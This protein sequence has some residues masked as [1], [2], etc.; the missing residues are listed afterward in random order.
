MST[1]NSTWSLH[2]KGQN[3]ELKERDRKTGSNFSKKE[4]EKKGSKPNQTTM[5]GQIIF[6]VPSVANLAT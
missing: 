2:Q 4:K 3:W 1:Y 5:M 6:T